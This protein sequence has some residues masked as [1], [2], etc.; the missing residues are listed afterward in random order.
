MP[1]ANTF[2]VYSGRLI[3]KGG[4][5]SFLI[6]LVL[7][8]LPIL[9]IGKYAQYVGKIAAEHGHLSWF[10]GGLVILLAAMCWLV[11]VIG[12]W[13][14]PIIFV[15]HLLLYADHARSL[16]IVDAVEDYLYRH[17]LGKA[18]PALVY[19]EMNEVDRRVPRKR[20]AYFVQQR[21]RWKDRYLEA[22]RKRTTPGLDS[23]DMYEARLLEEIYCYPLKAVERG[24][25]SAMEQDIL[26]RFIKERF[27]SGYLTHG[28]WPQIAEKLRSNVVLQTFLPR[29]FTDDFIAD[30]D[31]YI[32]QGREAVVRKK[33]LQG[34]I[35]EQETRLSQLKSAFKRS[36]GF[37]RTQ[38]SVQW[39]TAEIHLDSAK[40][41]LKNLEDTYG[42]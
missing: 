38:I 8:L 19:S 13:L 1:F 33:A 20:A 16:G 32:A 31:S 30:C 7:V 12:I 14:S 17:F 11:G 25:E 36:S 22:A 2:Y 6:F 42:I 10:W 23:V 26:S 39:D 35:A 24:Y 4:P 21:S 3:I 18:H 28:Q 15:P 9:L 27:R 41:E 40:A 5:V 34:Y 37:S 29:F